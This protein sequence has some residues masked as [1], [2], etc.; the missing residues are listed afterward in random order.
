[1]RCRPDD[2]LV[3][4]IAQAADHLLAHAQP[5]AQGI[6]WI[7]PEMGGRALAGF[8]HGASGI[9]WAL[10]LAANLTGD[11]RY[12]DAAHASLQYERTL[13]GA[14]AQNWRDLRG[15][16]DGDDIFM[17]A[18]CH[19]APGVGLARLGLRPLLDDPALG[20]ELT[21]ALESTRAHGFGGGHS[22]CHGDFGNLE[23]FVAAAEALQQPALLDQARHVASALLAGQ[24]QSGWRC[25][26]PGGVETP[27]LMVGIAGIGYALLRLASPS[28]TPS[29]L[30]MAPP[31]CAAG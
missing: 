13:Y 5:Q 1:W 10:A 26:V 16:D 11:G 21:A 8:S 7:V 23:L 17:W 24:A 29:V 30:Q 22:L 6:G 14:A 20:G 18:W 25:G 2:K 31:R 12:R 15:A 9:A 27:G 28:L 19:G 3:T 4:L